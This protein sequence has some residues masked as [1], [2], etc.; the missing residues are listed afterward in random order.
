MRDDLNWREMDTFSS[1]TSRK[2]ILW[3]V[4]CL[5]LIAFSLIASA[6]IPFLWESKSLWY[7]IGFDKTLLQAGKIAGLFAANLF[8]IQI[9]LVLKVPFL[10][11]LVGLDRLYRIH[12]L[13]GFAILALAVLHASLVIVPEGVDNLPIGWKFWPEMIGAAL[14]L[15]VFL[16]VISA[17]FKS[18]LMSYHH[19]RYFHRPLGY[20]LILAAGAHILFVS[21]S[22]EQTVPR[23]SLFFIFSMLF[24]A[25]LFSKIG[26]VQKAKTRSTV[27][28]LNQLNGNIISLKVKPPSSFD[29][30]PGQFVFLQL[31]GDNVS[32]EPHPFT[33]ASS[34]GASPY[35]QFFIKQSGDWTSALHEIGKAE[36]SLQG[37]FGLF[38]Y[39]EKPQNNNLIFLAAGVGITPMLS[40]LLHISGQQS[41]PSI[42]L[43]WSLRSRKDMFLPNELKQLK[44]SLSSFTVD[45][46]YTREG[47]N[48]RLDVTKLQTLLNS[49]AKTSAVFLCG[50][51]KMM[52]EMKKN[53]LAIGFSRN[54][55]FYEKFSL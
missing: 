4:F 22:F 29:H 33:I 16:A 42:H 38:S 53:L 2:R 40:M 52:K 50:P 55:I 37:P 41:Q 36:A 21:D 23:Y 43:I 31:H 24:L 32:A 3:I 20:I 47:A 19:W 7:K 34:P 6:S 26:Q 28:G 1:T 27:L 9:I 25:V 15:A 5:C 10:D 17:R 46:I 30:V 14:L 13:N 35:L 12:Q 45:I 44:A 54:K 8:V 48:G 49:T 18:R 51:D 39:L 11:K